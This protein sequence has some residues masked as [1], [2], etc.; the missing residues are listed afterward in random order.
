MKQLKIGNSCVVY[1]WSCLKLNV[2]ACARGQS[3]QLNR[4]TWSV[5][6]DDDDDDDQAGF[7]SPS[8]LC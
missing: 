7:R 4:L 6:E 8:M 3:L 2:S 5:C 1:G